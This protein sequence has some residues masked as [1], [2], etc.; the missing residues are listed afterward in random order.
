[1]CVWSDCIL[2][3]GSIHGVCLQVLHR[4]CAHADVGFV[5]LVQSAVLC[6]QRFQ[7]R[8]TGQ[9]AL[10]AG[11]GSSY[12]ALALAC[13]LHGHIGLSGHILQQHVL[14]VSSAGDV[15]SLATHAAQKQRQ[16]RDSRSVAR[17][18]ADLKRRSLVPVLVVIAIVLFQNFPFPFPQLADF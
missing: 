2:L 18:I 10:G 6:V 4:R 1:M 8:N 5:C 9:C 7:A 12:D 13:R 14:P 17:S 11:Q 15:D 16:F 3:P